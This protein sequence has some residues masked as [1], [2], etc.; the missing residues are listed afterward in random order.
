MFC[1]LVKYVSLLF[2]IIRFVVVFDEKVLFILAGVVF[3]FGW[4]GAIKLCS[5]GKDICCFWIK[6]LVKV[7]GALVL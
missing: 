3:A 4:M 5:I 2:G 6:C 7:K 1:C